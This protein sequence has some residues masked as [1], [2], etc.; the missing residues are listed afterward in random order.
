MNRPPDAGV[1]AGAVAL[2]RFVKPMP[3]AKSLRWRVRSAREVL[4]R[5]RGDSMDKATL[6][7]ALLRCAGIPAR[8]HWVACDGALLRGLADGIREV[9]VPLPEAR[10]SNAFTPHVGR[11]WR[12]LRATLPRG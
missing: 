6:A 1:P 11:T 10:L 12:Q 5:G 3:L 7:V 8:L 4:S 9:P 2:Y